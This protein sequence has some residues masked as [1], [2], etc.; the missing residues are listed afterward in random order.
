MAREALIDVFTEL[1]LLL[2]FVGTCPHQILSFTCIRKHINL[3]H[4]TF[5]KITF[6]T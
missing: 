5:S 3:F 2:L 1:F 4:I 6:R